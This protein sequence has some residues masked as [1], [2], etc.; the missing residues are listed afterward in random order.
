MT[1]RATLR[2]CGRCADGRMSLDAAAGRDPEGRWV[3]WTC[4][5]QEVERRC[6]CGGPVVRLHRATGAGPLVCGRCRVVQREI[7]P[8]R[9]AEGWYDTGYNSAGVGTWTCPSCGTDY[10]G[11]VGGCDDC[12]SVRRP[13]RGCGAV[14]TV[15]RRD[16]AYCETCL[17]MADRAGVGANCPARVRA[18]REIVIAQAVP[19]GTVGAGASPACHDAPK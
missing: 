3:C 7:A 9:V 12:R 8:V 5:W 2:R 10:L 19:E 6:P 13:C 16:P 11:H 17:D 14:V 18:L 4:G 15:Q 1:T